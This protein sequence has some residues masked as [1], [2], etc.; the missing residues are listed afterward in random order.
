MELCSFVGKRWNLA[1]LERRDYVLQP[2]RDK[3][4]FRLE[5][6]SVGFEVWENEI[7]P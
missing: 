4:A 6:R 5:E 3:G 1:I 2:W 7:G